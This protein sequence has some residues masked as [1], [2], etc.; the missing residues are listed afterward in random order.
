MHELE[1]QRSSL[2][3]VTGHLGVLVRD[4]LGAAGESDARGEDAIDKHQVFWGFLVS[5]TLNP[6]FKQRL[7]EEAQ[8][9]G[10]AVDEE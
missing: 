2:V 3:R 5:A 6:S 4:V 8:C 7:G 1:R 9:R 10:I